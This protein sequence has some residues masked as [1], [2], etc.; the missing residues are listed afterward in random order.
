MHWDNWRQASPQKG[1]FL[2]KAGVD[3]E[4]WFDVRTL[5][6]SGKR[7]R[8]QGP[9][10]PHLIVIVDTLP[11]KVQLLRPSAATSAR[12]RP[13]SASRSCIPSWIVWRSNIAWRPI[14][15][16]WQAS[17]PSD[18]KMYHQQQIPNIRGEVTWYPQTNASATIEIPGL[19][20]T[21]MAGNPGRKATHNV[22]PS[23]AVA[24]WRI[25]CVSHRWDPLGESSGRGMETRWARGR[26]L[27]ARPDSNQRLLRLQRHALRPLRQPQGPVLIR[28]SRL[29]PK[30]A[31]PMGR[32]RM[33]ESGCIP[34]IAAISTTIK[35]DREPRLGPC[36][37]RQSARH[38]SICRRT[39]AGRCLESPAFNELS[40]VLS[41]PANRFL[42]CTASRPTGPVAIPAAPITSG[43]CPA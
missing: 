4:Y 12:S 30:R 11:P 27:L 9:H 6:R 15:P 35:S 23:V 28:G 26:R 16:S 14:P 1:F 36:D 43:R 38:A 29:G 20:M 41:A 25:R 24:T 5:D 10:V 32:P 7:V 21:D 17:F 39:T 42:R 19:R 34:A 40:A 18:R 8:P 3:G 2:F 13:R 31:I 33:A 37:P 22:L